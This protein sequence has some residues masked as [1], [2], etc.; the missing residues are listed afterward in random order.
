M[1]IGKNNRIDRLNQ[2]L[3]ITGEN[4]IDYSDYSN[5]EFQD[6]REQVITLYKFFLKIKSSK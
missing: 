6:I 5:N 3:K 1:T 2:Q 4:L